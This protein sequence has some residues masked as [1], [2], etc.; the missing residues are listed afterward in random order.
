MAVCIGAGMQVHLGRL[1][2]TSL[3]LNQRG[4]STKPGLSSN[5]PRSFKSGLEQLMPRS[6]ENGHQ[7]DC[8][9]KNIPE[10]E[11]ARARA[12]AQFIDPRK[13]KDRSRSNLVVQAPSFLD[14]W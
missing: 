13:H 3:V 8:R 11:S 10:R 1:S 12:R 9:K 6:T 14:S 7:K 4:L 5:W 2:L